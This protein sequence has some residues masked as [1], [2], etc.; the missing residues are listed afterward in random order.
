MIVATP[1]A[2]GD[3]MTPARR[4]IAELTKKPAKYGNKRAWSALCGRWFD[5]IAERERGEQ[6]RQWEMAGEIGGLVYQPRWLLYESPRLS[7]TADFA[8]SQDGEF[9]VEDVKG[10]L[11]RDTRTRLLWLREKFGIAVRLLRKG[12]GGW[13][14]V[15]I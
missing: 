14:E 7:Y 6:L 13:E 15:K 10:V 8:Y 4:A 9:V 5:S 11:T 1:R 3:G 2:E 12:K